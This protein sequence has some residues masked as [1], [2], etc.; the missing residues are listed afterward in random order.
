MG[1]PVHEP[2][3][4]PPL[5]ELHAHGQVRRRQDDL[6]QRGAR[7]HT[8]GEGE[9]VSSGRASNSSR[10]KRESS[11]KPTN[12]DNA[13]GQA[14][15]RVPG[16]GAKTPS[17]GQAAGSAPPRQE[18]TIR[19]SLSASL[20]RARFKQ[21]ALA[22][23]ST[24][25]GCPRKLHWFSTSRT[26]YSTGG[27]SPRLRS[28]T[29]TWAR[30][31]TNGRRSQRLRLRHDPKIRSREQGNQAHLLVHALVDHK[32]RNAWMRKEQRRWSVHSAR[33]ESEG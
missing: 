11:P 20:L 24:M 21:R 18:Q 9:K 8:G 31:R 1:L 25:Q 5:H 7:M 33:A 13:I 12:K 2:K 22:C 6:L 16:G 19:S 15:P 30:T 32:P 23:R 29:A 27:R 26:T 28:F 14:A 3:E 10:R 17:L 4:I